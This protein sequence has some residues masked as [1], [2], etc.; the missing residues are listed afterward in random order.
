MLLFEAMGQTLDVALGKKQIRLLLIAALLQEM[1]VQIKTKRQYKQL[2]FRERWKLLYQHNRVNVIQGYFIDIFDHRK[3][4]IRVFI[5]VYLASN[6]CFWFQ[7]FLRW[8]SLW[9]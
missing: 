6:N 4:I 2:K 1:K 8:S 5:V 9:L 3:T 7:D